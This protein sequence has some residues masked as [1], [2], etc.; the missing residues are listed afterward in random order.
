MIHTPPL[1]GRDFFCSICKKKIFTPIMNKTL[2]KQAFPLGK[3]CKQVQV[4]LLSIKIAGA[5]HGINF[6]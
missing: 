2:K 1:I 4:E 6:G 3:K 5:K